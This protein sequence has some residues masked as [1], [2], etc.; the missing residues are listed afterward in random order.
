MGY[1]CGAHLEH[2][3]DSMVIDNNKTVDVMLLPT[4]NPNISDYTNSCDYCDSPAKYLVTVDLNKINWNPYIKE[5][6]NYDPVHNP[7]YVGDIIPDPNTVVCENCK[8]S[9][10]DTIDYHDP[11]SVDTIG[12]SIADISI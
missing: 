5:I 10:A 2:K 11:V 9:G 8:L 1:C 6:D 7:N 12:G 3:I 4:T